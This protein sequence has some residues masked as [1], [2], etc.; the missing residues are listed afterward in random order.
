VTAAAS[1]R[2][3]ITNDDGIGSEGLRMLAS[4][5]VQAGWD[6]VVAAPDRQASGSGA[7]MTAVQA[8]GQV[9]IERR[10]LPGIEAVPAYAVQAAPG[11]IAFTAVRGAFGRRPDYLLS[12]INLG[13]NTGKAVLHS[14]TVGAAMTAATYGIRAAAFS[15]DARDDSDDCQWDL[16]SDVAGEILPAL[17]GIPSGVVLNVNI[18]NAPD[19]RISGIRQGRLAAGGAVELSIVEATAGYLHVTMAET[20]NRPVPGTDSAL[21]AAGYAAVTALQPVCEATPAGLPWPAG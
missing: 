4:A 20:G 1:V 9:I 5:A 7:A 3:V 19:G 18:P 17:A 21:L 10:R 8:D 14:G 11:F 16:A 2:A 15:L 13:P 6:V 12:G